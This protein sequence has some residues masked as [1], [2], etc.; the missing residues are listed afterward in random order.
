MR[1]GQ[2]ARSLDIT[3]K[4][5]VDFLGDNGK[6]INNHPNIKLE[7][8]DE[9]LVIQAFGKPEEHFFAKPQPSIKKEEIVKDIKPDDE[10]SEIE[11]LKTTP[12]IIDEESTDIVAPVLNNEE[13]ILNVVETKEPEL[14]KPEDQVEA[15]NEASLEEEKDSPEY[16]P[17]IEVIDNVE[18]I[19]APKIELPGLKVLGKIELPEPKQ[20]EETSE[21]EDEQK[22]EKSTEEKIPEVRYYK[23]QKRNN[24]PRL[25][26]EQKEERRLRSKRDRERR[27]KEKETRDKAKLEKQLKAKRRKHYEAKLKQTDTNSSKTKKKKSN[28]PSET[29]NNKPQPKTALGK[30][31]RWLNT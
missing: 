9:Q 23:P 4:Q 19:K 14:A 20:V 24:R 22:V 5:V 10:L 18:I 25:T 26:E 2:L 31:W 8:K 3:T 12:Q 30:F 16:A 27:L 6:E 29:E 13:D 1:L 28:Q 15:F 17:N 11:E 21:D 7:D